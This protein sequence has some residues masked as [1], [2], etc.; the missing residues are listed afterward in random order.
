MLPQHVFLFVFAIC[1]NC[2]RFPLLQSE[3]VYITLRGETICRKGTKEFDSQIC[4]LL[5]LYCFTL[6]NLH[7]NTTSGD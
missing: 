1:Y 6:S 3:A 5:E 2:Q 4:V 7:W